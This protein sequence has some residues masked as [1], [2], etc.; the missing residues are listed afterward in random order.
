MEYIFG[1]VGLMLA[2]C[3]VLIFRNLKSIQRV[4]LRNLILLFMVAGDLIVIFL[5]YKF[6]TTDVILTARPPAYNP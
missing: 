3:H 2:F 6:F 5:A 1:V 4:D